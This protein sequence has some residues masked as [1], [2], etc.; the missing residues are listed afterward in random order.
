MIDLTRNLK[1]L[2]AGLITFFGLLLG[3]KWNFF[4]AAL[5]ALGVYTGVYL[6]SKP[7]VM[8]GNTDMEAIENGKE[9]A[10]IFNE[11]QVNT[12]FLKTL[13]ESFKDTD[14]KEKS[15]SLARTAT[16]I[17]KY[18]E[19]NP[20]EISK[21]RHFMDYYMNTAIEILKNYS[22]L[23]QANVSQDKFLEI[24][25]KTTRSLDL[26]NQIFAR[27]RD[28]YHKDKITQLEVETDLLEQ[29]IR[30]GGDIK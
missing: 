15:L 14:I 23:N 6:I 21:S 27:Q 7:R 19:G 12:G 25:E 22:N 1:S 20:R 10:Q 3:L 28:S 5:L 16:D 29:T 24:K 13:A 30:L 2:I 18:L 11:Y 4:V 9:L 17:E 8:I 26:L